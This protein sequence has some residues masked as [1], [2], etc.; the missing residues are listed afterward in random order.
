MNSC[1]RDIFIFRENSNSGT[2]VV[3]VAFSGGTIHIPLSESMIPNAIGEVIWAVFGP[4][5][6]KQFTV[7]KTSLVVCEELTFKVSE[8]GSV[9]SSGRKRQW[10]KRQWQRDWHWPW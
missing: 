4:V 9:M 8:F 1:N 2:V 3:M 7:L 10:Q 5:I 6:C